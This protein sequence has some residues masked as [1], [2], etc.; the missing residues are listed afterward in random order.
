MLLSWNTT[1]AAASGPGRKGSERGAAMIERTVFDLRIAEGQALVA[2]AERSGWV[3]DEATRGR[4]RAARA[5]LAGALLALARRLDPAGARGAA[6]T[7]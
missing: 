5:A 4:T 7:T 2:R 3:Q 1:G 6:A